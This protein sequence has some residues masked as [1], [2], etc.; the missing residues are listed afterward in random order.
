MGIYGPDRER[1]PFFVAAVCFRR[2]LDDSVQRNLDV[3]QVGLG[4]IMEVGIET[5][6]NS[7]VS[8]NKDVLLS[9]K[10]HYHRFQSEYNVSVRFAPCIILPVKKKI[11]ILTPSVATNRDIDN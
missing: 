11:G 4:K 3:R 5:S 10:L 6:E 2:E 9:L 1:I 7:L 8:H